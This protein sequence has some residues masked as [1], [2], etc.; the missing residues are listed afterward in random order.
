MYVLMYIGL[1]IVGMNISLYIYSIHM[2][3]RACFDAKLKEFS[4][5]SVSG[6]HAYKYKFIYVAVYMYTVY[7]HML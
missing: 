7:I 2:I 3:V 6:I 4:I 1:R 5:I